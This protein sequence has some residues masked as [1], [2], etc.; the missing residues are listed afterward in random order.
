MT[1]KILVV[2]DSQTDNEAICAIL[3]S[4]GYETIKA[5]DGESGVEMAKS[6]LPDFIVMDIVMP[7]INGFQACKSIVKDPA[8]AHIPVVICS[9]KQQE[10][11]KAWGL[12]NGA[13]HYF[14]KPVVG[15]ELLGKV[16]ELTG[17]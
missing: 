1:K 4:G 17:E 15:A 2:D 11:D 10:T 16:K 9:N 6:E 7:G 12:R 5:F 8:T 14:V 3:R 13:R